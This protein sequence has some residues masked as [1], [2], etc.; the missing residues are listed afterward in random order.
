MFLR[1]THDD[2]EVGERV[3]LVARYDKGQEFCFT[4]EDFNEEECQLRVCDIEAHED[5]IKTTTEED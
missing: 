3:V 4:Y 1:F 5:Q 2:K